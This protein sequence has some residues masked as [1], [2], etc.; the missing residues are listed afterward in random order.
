MFGVLTMH[1]AR[2]VNHGHSFEGA[3]DI[4]NLLRLHPLQHSFFH[5]F[6]PK[7]DIV[8]W[9]QPKPN[10]QLS[11]FHL[12]QYDRDSK[13]AFGKYHSKYGTAIK[14][15]VDEKEGLKK[16]NQSKASKKQCTS[17]T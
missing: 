16:K 15:V 2:L 5:L 1:L 7:R 4:F 17:F 11:K 14:F 13:K 3:E 6:D 8:R 10:T 12:V 9:P